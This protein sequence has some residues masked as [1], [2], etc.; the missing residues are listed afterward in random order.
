MT[1]NGRLDDLIAT[2]LFRVK[3]ATTYFVWLDSFALNNATNG[4]KIQLGDNTE[5][6]SRNMIWNKISGLWLPVNFVRGNL[7]FFFFFN[8]IN[9]YEYVFSSRK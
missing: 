6:I 8:L 9:C 5:K 2:Y 1:A 3:K 4:V 7:L